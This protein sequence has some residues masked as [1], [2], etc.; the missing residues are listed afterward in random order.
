MIRLTERNAALRMLLF[1]LQVIF[2]NGVV[3]AQNEDE[4]LFRRG[5]AEYRQEQFAAARD[6][7]RKIVEKRTDSPRLQAA[8]VMLAKALY[9][10]GAFSAADSVGQNLR[11]GFKDGP[12]TEWTYY[13][14][15][16][17]TLRTGNRDRSLSLLAWLASSAQDSRI[18]A[19]SLRALRYTVIPFVDNGKAAA[20]LKE[21]GI[22]RSALDSAEPYGLSD[23]FE[24]E[25]EAFSPAP[26]AIPQKETTRRTSPVLRIGLLTPLSGSNSEM[27]NQ[28]LRGVRAAFADTENSGDK[29]VELVVGDTLSDP[30]TAVLKVREMVEQGVSAIIGPVYSI[31]NITAAVEANSHGIPFIA[32]TATDVGLTDIGRKV[33]Q[34]NFTPVIQAEAL[35]EYAV[36]TLSAKNVAVIAS[37]DRWGEALAATFER[38][39]EKR[40]AK[41]ILTSL[42]QP[43]SENEE[44]VKIVRDIRIQAPKPLS[45]IDS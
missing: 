34:L 31:S 38:E 17:C 5:L 21:Y 4:A 25:D 2:L 45:F 44:D 15:S 42:F 22:D 28:L 6:D 24:I 23:I 27:G 9:R 26:A 13:L 3:Y 32:P 18:K 19:K 29:Q 35:A 39:I 11:H 10:L 1:I 41:V 16:A 40:G 12:Y 43:D 30:V 20:V 37:R 33:F 8:Q 7:F 14:E 36:N